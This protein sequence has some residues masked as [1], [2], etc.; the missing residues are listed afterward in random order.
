M[1]PWGIKHEDAVR[2]K[3]GLGQDIMPTTWGTD[4]DYY[5]AADHCRHTLYPCPCWLQEASIVTIPPFQVSCPHELDQ[6]FQL[7]YHMH[8]YYLF[9]R[10]YDDL[11]LVID[12][13]EVW[14]VWW[15][16]LEHMDLV[17]ISCHIGVIFCF[18]EY[19]RYFFPKYRI[20]LS[21][22]F[23]SLVVWWWFE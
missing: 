21:S 7:S 10:A 19:R 2:R 8:S 12:G 6:N 3:W 9:A 20:L 17:S 13:N 4:W 5:G 16:S 1:S 15:T 18:Q 23:E 22:G 11:I 14:F